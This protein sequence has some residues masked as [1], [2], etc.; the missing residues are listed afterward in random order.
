MNNA[1]ENVLTACL[2]EQQDVI[3]YFCGAQLQGVVSRLDEYSVELRQGECRSV[4][5]L[6]SIDAVSKE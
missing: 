1:F 3:I 6:A 4:I 2:E 5:R